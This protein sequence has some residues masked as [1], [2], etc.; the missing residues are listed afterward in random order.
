MQQ[1][2]E[3]RKIFCFVCFFVCLFKKQQE[4]ISR[5]HFKLCFVRS[6]CGGYCGMLPKP[7]APTSRLRQAV[8]PPPQIPAVWST[9][10]LLTLQTIH[11]CFHPWAEGKGNSCAKTG[12]ESRHKSS[13]S[14]SFCDNSGHPRICVSCGIWIGFVF[15]LWLAVFTLSRYSVR[16]LYAQTSISVLI[17]RKPNL[18]Q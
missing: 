3:L 16:I 8:S 17:S 18:R 4:S 12:Q 14:V 5:W 10:D 1:Q 6:K 7:P 15:W 9:L 2:L 11:T 13:L